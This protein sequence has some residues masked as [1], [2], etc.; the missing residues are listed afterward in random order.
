MVFR[1]GSPWKGPWKGPQ[2]Q[3]NVSRKNVG[4]LVPGLGRSRD[5]FRNPM[6]ENDALAVLYLEKAL[7]GPS[8]C[9]FLFLFEGVGAWTGQKHVCESRQEQSLTKP[10]GMVEPPLEVANPPGMG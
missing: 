7:P 4:K 9:Q 8:H 3:P 2:N 6:M 10:P 1:Q 5:H